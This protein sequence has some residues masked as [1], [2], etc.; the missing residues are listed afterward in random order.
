MS[1]LLTLKAAAERLSLSISLVQ[2]LAR[3]A[4][5]AVEVRAGT[6][7]VEDV[8][9]DLVRYLDTGFPVPKRL[10]QRVIRL[11]AEEVDRWAE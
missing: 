7:A 5:Y 2:K 4:E 9:V 1:A 8:P 10:T 11:R 6:R 3:A